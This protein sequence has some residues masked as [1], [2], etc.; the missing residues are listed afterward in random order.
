MYFLIF[1]FYA[2]GLSQE[3][4]A[5]PV[6]TVMVI[7]CAASEELEVAFCMIGLLNAAASEAA[8]LSDL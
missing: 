7:W 3:L 5:K 8:D 6:A 4:G 1:G 2:A